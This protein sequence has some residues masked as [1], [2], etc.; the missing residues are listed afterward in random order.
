MTVCNRLEETGEVYNLNLKTMGSACDFKLGSSPEDSNSIS[1]LENNKT[2][3]IM[4]TTANYHHFFLN[5]MIPAL[6]V[7]KELGGNDLH[8]VLCGQAIKDRQDNFDSLIVELLQENKISYTQIH[9]S[10]FDYI[11]AKNFVSINGADLGKGIPLLYSYLLAKYNIVAETP[12]KK[13][14]VSRKKYSSHDIRI[15]NEE[16]LENYFIKKGFQV[17][18][19]EDI[20]TFKEQFELFYSCSTLAALSGSGLTSLIFMQKNQKVIEIVSELMVGYDMSD[21]GV[22]TIRYDIHGHYEEMSILKNHTYLSVLNM[23]KQAELVKS[24]LENIEL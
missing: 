14:Y 15:D 1:F 13:I 2:Y 8:F 18:Y 3:V 16:V 5:L 6:L 10:Q 22:K 12:N 17:V 11:N 20:T 9:D 24:K 21:D 23:E 19:P 4:L 7:L